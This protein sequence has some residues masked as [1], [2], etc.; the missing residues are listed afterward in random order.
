[1]A[2]DV[3]R[4]EF[5]RLCAAA[6]GAAAALG[7]PGCGAGG[8]E[9]AGPG[10]PS[11]GGAPDSH[12]GKTIAAFCDV[13]I[14][15]AHR[16]PRR[17]PGALDVG[18]VAPFFDPA[19][20]AAQFVPTLVALLDLRAQDDFDLHFIALVPAQR[21]TVLERLLADFDLL[22]FAV[23]LA[24]LAYYTAPAGAQHLGYPGANPGYVNDPDFSFGGVLTREIT[25]DGNLP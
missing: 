2:N 20:P 9:T 25:L 12:E 23:Q 11:L 19:L 6:A 13:V 3:T 24:K 4:R 16:D 7:L 18:A 14:P 21:E 17:A 1:M 5:L 15:G 10:L 22:D 8:G